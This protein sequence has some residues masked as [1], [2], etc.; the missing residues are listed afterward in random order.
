[1]AKR[2]YIGIDLGTSGVRACAIDQ[3]GALLGEA[4]APLPPSSSTV[5]GHFEQAPADWWQ[6][7]LRVLDD[8]LRDDSLQPA[9]IS[10]D[11]T[12]GTLL[13]C[14]ADGTPTGPALMYNDSRSTAE[15]ALL[16]DIAAPQAA[17][18]SPNSALAKLMYLHRHAQVGAAVYALHQADWIAARLGAPLGLSDENN[19]LKMGYDP[20]ERR[21]PGWI[22]RCGIDQRLLPRVLPV[23]RPLGELRPELARRWH[24]QQPVRLIAG[25]TDSNAATLASG[26]RQ[27]GEASTALGST[28]VLKVLSAQ[29]VFDPA[30]GVYS[31]RLG[32]LWL[33]GGAS[34]S[35]GNVLR[36]FFSEQQLAQLSA[37]IDP[38][39]DSGLDYYPL[40]TPGER[41][42]INDPD[43]PPRLSP[44]PDDQVQFLQGLLEGIARIEQLGYQ[45]LHALGAPYPTRVLSSGGGA[46]NLA[47]QAIRQRLL[48]CAVEQ[49]VQ[50]EAAYGSAL[51]AA[52]L[53]PDEGSESAYPGIAQNAVPARAD[54][55]P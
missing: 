10:V 20:L 18:H 31:H 21:W 51:I 35:G 28:L 33:A 24:C 44:R 26:I 43:M 52:G 17:V 37:Q 53:F 23:G 19:A 11:G 8:L 5:T 4:R 41:F 39:S 48:G 25:T 32:N 1:M 38:D 40:L 55:D 45:H 3:R 22:A 27:I 49:S 2:A 7:C 47:W 29:P 30:S 34:N 13:S 9:A 50:T 16:E 6:A 12:S 46:S 54:S 14:E 36:H 42:P 15:A